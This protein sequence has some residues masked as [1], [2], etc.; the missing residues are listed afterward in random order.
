MKEEAQLFGK[1]NSLVGIITDPEPTEQGENRPGILLLNAGKVHR[2][3][4]N[5]LYVKMARQF[6]EMG[7]RTAARTCGHESVTAR[8]LV[9]YAAHSGSRQLV[10]EMVSKFW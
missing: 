9:E 2:A 1:T 10:T 7:F 6:A 4:P 3:G 8:S 5:R